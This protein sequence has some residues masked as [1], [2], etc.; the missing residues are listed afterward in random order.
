[1]IPVLAATQVRLAAGVTTLR[2]GFAA[3]A[4]SPKAEL[5]Q[6]LF[7]GHLLVLYDLRGSLVKVGLGFEMEF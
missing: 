1:M 6:D 4:A 5:E 7:A 3:L 2:K